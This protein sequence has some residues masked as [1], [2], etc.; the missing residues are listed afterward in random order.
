MTATTNNSFN[1]YFEPWLY[2]SN[3]KLT[4]SEDIAALGIPAGSYDFGGLKAEAKSLTGITR[5]RKTVNFD[6]VFDTE[7]VVFCTIASDGN[8]YP[9]TVGVRNVTTTGFELYQLFS[10]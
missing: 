6:Q 4:K 2:L 5:E 7:P 8:L 9:L 1:F 3:S 10:N